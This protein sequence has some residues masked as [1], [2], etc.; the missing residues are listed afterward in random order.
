M[1]ESILPTQTAITQQQKLRWSNINI[2]I[3]AQNNILMMTDFTWTVHSPQHGYSAAYPRIDHTLNQAIGS[4]LLLRAE[5]PRRL[6]DRAV[7][8][9]DRYDINPNNRTF[10]LKFFYFMKNIAQFNFNSKIEIFQSENYKLVKKVAQLSAN[11]NPNPNWTPFNITLQPE[12][13]SS[14]N[15]WFYMVC[16][17]TK[18]KCNRFRTFIIFEL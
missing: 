1:W 9:S 17:T 4:Y 10:C 13:I 5:S 6:G 15:M 3:D 16:I 14:T 18:F 11:Y 2:G 12:N 7:L 8:M